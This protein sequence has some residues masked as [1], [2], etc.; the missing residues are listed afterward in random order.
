[1]S[2]DKQYYIDWINSVKRG[3]KKISTAIDNHENVNIEK[4]IKAAMA[5]DVIMADCILFLLERVNMTKQ[6]QESEVVDQ[7][8]NMFGMR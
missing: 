1:M 2:N 4:C 7:L 6:E 8:K 5:N 3:S